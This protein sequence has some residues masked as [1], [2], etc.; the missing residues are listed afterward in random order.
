VRA[1]VLHDALARK[2]L[3]RAKLEPRRELLLALAPLLAAAVREAGLHHGCGLVAPIPSHPLNDLRR[4][5]SPSRDL[6]RRLSRIL[7]IPLSPRL[8]R[9]RIR[10]GGAIK[11][12]SAGE[13]RAAAEREFRVRGPARGEHILLVDDVMTTGTSA[14]TCARFLKL[15]GAGSV[16]LAVWARRATR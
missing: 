4:G 12:L 15:A 10:P 1:A 14:N 2:F 6:A 11:R 7:G 13:R 16:R 3:L 5:F 8:L 9:R